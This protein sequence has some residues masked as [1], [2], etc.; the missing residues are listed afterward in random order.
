MV[1]RTCS[2]N[3]GRRS[4]NLDYLWLKGKLQSEGEV[5]HVI[6]KRCFNL[7]KLLR[8]LVDA[9]DENLPLTPLSRADERSALIPGKKERIQQHEMLQEKIFPE[10][11]N[12]R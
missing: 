5:I 3:T 1:L 10:A 7:S 9:K 4:C 8:Q 12:F 11:R 6:V 2:K